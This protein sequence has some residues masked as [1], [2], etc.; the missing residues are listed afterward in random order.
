HRAL[1]ACILLLGMLEG[2]GVTTVE[3]LHAA[4]GT[5]HPVQQ[6]M[7]EAHG[8]QCG[9]CTPGIVMSLYTAYVS[10][11]RPDVARVNDL[12]A[13][14]LGRCTGYGAIVK[15]AQGMHDLPRLPAA[16]ERVEADLARMRALVH[17][18]TVA[19]EGEGTRI[20]AP[21]TLDALAGLCETH[22]D[23]TILSGA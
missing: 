6:A 16:G 2:R 14:N 19:L 15:A 1:N 23:A 9:F 8:S 3:R 7:V 5:L 12:L 4:D 18:E 17:G 22:P 20:Y 11:P 21:A 13:G 10:E